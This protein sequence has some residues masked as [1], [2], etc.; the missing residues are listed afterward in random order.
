MI[1]SI[2]FP[3]NKLE[4]SYTPW[5]TPV[6]PANAGIQGNSHGRSIEKTTVRISTDQQA[7]WDFLCGSDI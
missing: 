3:S 7:K 1:D 2:N 6:I 4:D 5:N